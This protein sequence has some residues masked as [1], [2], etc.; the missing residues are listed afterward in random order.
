MNEFQNLKSYKKL[1]ELAKKNIDLTSEKIST[2]RI[3]EFISQNCGF[4]FFYG[5]EKIDKEILSSLFEL[6]NE[7]QVLAK[8]EAMQGGEVINY[9]EGHES[10]N[11]MVLHTALR[12]CFK[13]RRKEKNAIEASNLAYKEIEKLKKFI[14]RIDREGKFTD[15]IQIGIGGSI[16]GPHAMNQALNV[17]RKKKR[18]VHFV[19][20]VDPDDLVQTLRNVDLSKTLIVS[21]SKSGTTL[22]TVT[23]EEFVKKELHKK[24]LD[25]KEHLIAVTSKGSPMDNNNNYLEVFYIW[26]FVGGR[27]S[28]TSM[29]G[30]VALSFACGTDVYI[31][32]L[33]GA[34]DMD[35]NALLKDMK[36]N[37]PLLAALLGIWNRNFL[38]YPSVA[39][40]PYS[41]ALFYFCYQIQQY[42]MESNGKSIDRKAKRVTF[43]TGPVVFANIGTDA[44]HSFFQFLHQGTDITPIEFI[45]FKNSQ[46]NEDITFKETTSQQKLLSNL[47]GQAIALAK[48]KKSKNPNKNFEGNR[49]SSILLADKLTPYALGALMSYY[50]HKAAFQGFIWGINSFDQEGVQLGKVLADQMMNLFAH[51]KENFPWGEAFLKECGML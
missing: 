39:I 24:G 51:K 45:G 3:S 49:P 12:D 13:D 42:D 33:K 22:E 18:N 15:L 8:M 1:Q 46:Y 37:L 28:P 31:E 50:E 7:A 17:H 48:G 11:R 47:F 29:V 14:D 19:S 21:V 43:E 32:L 34:H 35:K 2:E 26:D 4:K 44:Q 36:N 27:F 23:N 10:D 41:S 20:N 38:K 6:A 40:I 5:L 9:I 25:P 30:A 16:L